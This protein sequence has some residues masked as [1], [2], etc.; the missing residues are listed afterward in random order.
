MKYFKY[1]VRF[2]DWECKL[3]FDTFSYHFI[4]TCAFVFFFRWL[5]SLYLRF[6][7]THSR[8]N[9]QRP[10]VKL[11]DDALSSFFPRK[12]KPCLRSGLPDLRYYLT[13]C[14]I[15][16]TSS[17]RQRHTRSSSSLATWFRCKADSK[18]CENTKQQNTTT[19]RLFHLLDQL[20][21]YIFIFLNMSDYPFFPPLPPPTNIFLLMCYLWCSMFYQ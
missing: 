21:I 10:D 20:S 1:Y 6:Q 14:N 3:L 9:A 5:Y 12:K 19:T 4:G 18:P 2:L 11:G 16:T 17:Q 13:L 15:K 7:T 8:W